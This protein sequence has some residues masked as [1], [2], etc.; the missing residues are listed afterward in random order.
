ML[1][2][3]WLSSSSFLLSA[4]RTDFFPEQGG[5]AIRIRAGGCGWGWGWLCEGWMLE[6]R[7]CGW[8]CVWGKV[9]VGLR[10]GVVG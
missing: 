8:R 9:D 3:P 2:D 1:S 10:W 4:L 7:E 6:E 5:P